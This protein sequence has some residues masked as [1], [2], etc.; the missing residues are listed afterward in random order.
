MEERSS[1]DRSDSQQEKLSDLS[2]EQQAK[3]K[4]TTMHV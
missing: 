4:S 1:R 3:A 2:G